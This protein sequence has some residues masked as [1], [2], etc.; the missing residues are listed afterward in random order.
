[1]SLG[2]EV[3]WDGMGMFVLEGGYV[4]AVKGLCLI[5]F[6]VGEQRRGEERVFGF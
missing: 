2:E 1:M 5:A 4:M 3:G 6:D